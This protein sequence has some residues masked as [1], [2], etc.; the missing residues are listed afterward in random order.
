M[1]ENRLEIKEGKT[2]PAQQILNEIKRFKGERIQIGH[3]VIENHKTKEKEHFYYLDE[4]KLVELS[5]PIIIPPRKKNEKPQEIIRMIKVLSI[6][7]PCEQNFAYKLIMNKETLKN[8]EELKQN[9]NSFIAYDMNDLMNVGYMFKGFHCA[10]KCMNCIFRKNNMQFKASPYTI[11]EKY[12]KK[13]Y[14]KIMYEDYIV[15][16]EIEETEEIGCD[17]E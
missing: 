7:N 16:E 1:V 14:I 5:K 4:K 11:T 17:E 13:Y 10:I 6:I 2:Y 12:D 15:K 8:L 3:A 9:P